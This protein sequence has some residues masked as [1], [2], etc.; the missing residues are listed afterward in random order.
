MSLRQFR[1]AL[2]I[3]IPGYH[4]SSGAQLMLL[5]SLLATTRR[6]VSGFGSHSL[7]ALNRTESRIE[8]A[9]D[10][11]SAPMNYWVSNFGISQRT[12]LLPVTH[13]HTRTP[14]PSC[15]FNSVII[16][17]FQSKG[18][19]QLLSCKNFHN[20]TSKYGRWLWRGWTVNEWTKGRRNGSRKR[21]RRTR[22]GR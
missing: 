2:I 21:S 17:H 5:L 6:R 9:V 22:I 20:T 12:T 7:T 1:V 10:G 18:A 8:V 13:T 19:P 14:L 4:S 16:A 15:K 3:P 11:A